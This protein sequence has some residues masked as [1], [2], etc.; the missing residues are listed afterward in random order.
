MTDANTLFVVA[1]AI[2]LVAGLI[3]LVRPAIV[4]RL[5]SIRDG[6]PAKYGLL[7][8]GMMLTAF[9]MLLAGFAIGYTTAAPLDLTPQT[10]S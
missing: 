9:G 4:R 3:T 6:E 8:A 2:L 7:I 1:G 5:F 10:S